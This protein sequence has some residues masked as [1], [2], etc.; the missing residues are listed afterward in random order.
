MYTRR[1]QILAI[2]LSSL[3]LAPAARLAWAS[4]GATPVAGKAMTQ[5][6]KKPS[7]SGIDVSYRLEGEPTTGRATRVVVVLSGVTDPE[8]SVRF[9]ADPELQLEGAGSAPA[10]LETGRATTFNL[11]VVPQSDGL[12]YLNV[13]TTQHGIGSSTSIPVQTGA[14][15]AAKSGDKLQSTPQGDKIRSMPVK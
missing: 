1:R 15:P 7:G 12:R 13:F 14:L 5:A 10:R 3:A 2:A 8:A 6:A 9:A 4:A 11:T